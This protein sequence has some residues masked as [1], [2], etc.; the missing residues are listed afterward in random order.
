[1]NLKIL[2]IVYSCIPGN[3]RGG[4]SKIV[5]ELSQAQAQLGHAV[6]IYTTN[7]NSSILAQVPLETPIKH[8]N[9]N[10]HYFPVTFR[11]WMWSSEM[12]RVLD[13]SAADYD[14]IHG[15]NTFLALNRYVAEAGRKYKIPIFYHTHG[16]L[17]PIVINQGMAKR[18]R[19]LLYIHLIEKANYRFAA[20]LFANTIYEVRQ[21]RDQGIETPVYIAPNGVSIKSIEAYHTYAENFRRNHK[22]DVDQPCI[23]FIGRIVPK[24]GIHLLLRAFEKLHDQFPI[25]LLVI[26]GDR[27][28]DLSYVADLDKFII[29]RSLEKNVVWTGFLDEE[30]KI[31]AFG[32]ASIFSHV[33]KSEGM[34]M[35]IL[36]AMGAGLPVIVSSECYM[37]KA[38]PIRSCHRNSL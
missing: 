29:E 38:A 26:G 7:Y 19:K 28:Q 32:A 21:I 10:I 37:S 3:Y 25:V 30:A 9:I 4:I 14:I 5:Y 22:I 16:A 24:K 27:K 13:T 33:S 15:H 31:G 8:E 34:A 11:K 35:S 2:Q 20:G 6:T 17:D 1:M 18:I 12:Q 36:E 23:L